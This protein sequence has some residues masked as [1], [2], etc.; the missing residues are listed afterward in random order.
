MSL[1]AAD[2]QSYTLSLTH[3]LLPTEA[4]KE[5]HAFGWNGSFEHLVEVLA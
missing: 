1:P 3:D 4:S 2:I 5:S